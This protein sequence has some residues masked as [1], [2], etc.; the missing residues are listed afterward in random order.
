MSEEN[1][2]NGA[3]AGI[4]V[5][6][7]TRV[8]SGPYATQILADHGAEVIKVEPPLGDEVR[9]WG[10]PFYEGDA[11]YFIGLNRN[12][13][14]I[15]I[16]LRQKEGQDVL[17]RL[18]EEADI[19]FENFKTGQMEK[20]G[21]GYEDVLKEKFPKLIYCRIS[22]YGADGPLSLIHI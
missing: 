13:R 14:S 16:D 6:D 10:P 9:D 12:K 3:L 20:F 1:S 22:G 2:K 21:L 8:L 17:L 4:K 11:S 19:V 7:L 5:V 15:G 18:L